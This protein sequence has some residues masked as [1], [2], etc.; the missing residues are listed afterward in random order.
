MLT[1]AELMERGWTRT[2]IAKFLP[3]P[4]GCETVNHWANFRGKD[5]YSWVKVWNAEQSEAFGVAFMN[6]WRGR[7]KAQLPV[8]ALRKIRSAPAPHI[9]PRTKEEIVRATLMAEMVGIFEEASRKGYRTP[10]K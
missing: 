9:R 1:R 4:D 8:L 7:M 5:T 2:L 10:H 3:R 6:C